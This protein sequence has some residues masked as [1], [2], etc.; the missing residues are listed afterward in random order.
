M[1]T[2]V[3]LNIITHCDTLGNMR[4]FFL[5]DQSW[6]DYLTLLKYPLTLGRCCSS[7]GKLH[8]SVCTR[9]WVQSSAGV[10]Q[11]P[12]MRSCLEPFPFLEM[13]VKLK[14]I[15]S[16]PTGHP[17]LLCDVGWEWAFSG[18]HMCLC[19]QS[20]SLHPFEHSIWTSIGRFPILG[21]YTRSQSQVQP[22]TLIMKL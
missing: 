13:R 16:L 20:F 21:E 10:G 7:V 12:S 1:C 15:L 2:T 11:H 17:V 8:P 6:I 14:L 9:P 22:K 18:N 3:L 5:Y 19:V 4:F